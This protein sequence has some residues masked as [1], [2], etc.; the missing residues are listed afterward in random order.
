M[1]QVWHPDQVVSERFQPEQRPQKG[2]KSE[3][4]PVTRNCTA[5]ATFFLCDWG[6][7]DGF[8]DRREKKPTR[9]PPKRIKSSPTGLAAS[10]RD[11]ATRTTG[12]T[13]E[14]PCVGRAL[15]AWEGSPG[16]FWLFWSCFRGIWRVGLRRLCPITPSLVLVNQG[17]LCF[18][19]RQAEQ[20]S[21]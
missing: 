11:R 5:T 18:P 19:P 6:R 7:R 12:V 8:G 21:G 2:D 10:V 15:G 9:N 1:V 3:L 17:N 16:K 4:S 13:M 14:C 20:P